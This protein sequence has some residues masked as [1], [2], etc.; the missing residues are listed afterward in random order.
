MMEIRKELDELTGLL[1]SEKPSAPYGNTSEAEDQEEDD[2]AYWREHR[3]GKSGEI[4]AVGTVQDFSAADQEDH[5]D[6]AGMV[7]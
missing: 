7:D 5:L 1:E 4:L 2:K 6:T 3:A